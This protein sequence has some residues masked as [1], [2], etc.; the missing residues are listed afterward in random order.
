[1]VTTGNLVGNVSYYNGSTRWTAVTEYT[2]RIGDLSYSSSTDHVSYSISAKVKKE[3]AMPSKNF[4]DIIKKKEVI[5]VR[6]DKLNLTFYADKTG[7][8]KDTTARGNF[9]NLFKTIMNN[10]G[11]DPDDIINVTCLTN[12]PTHYIV[13]VLFFRQGL[14]YKL[15]DSVTNR[16]SNFKYMLV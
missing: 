2:Y 15:I 5:Y 6:Q 14:I 13:N 8:L 7:S 12:S 10:M 9:I 4:K 16:D 11:Y 3:I 1:M